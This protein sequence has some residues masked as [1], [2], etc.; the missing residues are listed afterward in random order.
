MF[1]QF[2][3]L[4]ITKKR[5]S[6]QLTIIKGIKIN[7]NHNNNTRIFLQFTK[8]IRT[9]TTNLQLKNNFQLRIN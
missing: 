3:K 7:N 8:F 5:L 6:F 1:L 9:K 4:T 2:E